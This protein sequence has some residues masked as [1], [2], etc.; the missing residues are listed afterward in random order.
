MVYFQW[1]LLLF[2]KLNWRDRPQDCDLY[3]LQEVSVKTVN[4]SFISQVPI[5]ESYAEQQNSAVTYSNQAKVNTK[6]RP[7]LFV[8]WFFLY[9]FYNNQQAFFFLAVISV[10]LLDILSQRSEVHINCLALVLLRASGIV[11]S[12]ALILSVIM[13]TGR[14]LILCV[15]VLFLF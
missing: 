3:F 5:P 10:F 15:C 11:A 7:S 2:S 13:T 12:L 1:F 14:C 9:F 4:I 6:K 8:Y